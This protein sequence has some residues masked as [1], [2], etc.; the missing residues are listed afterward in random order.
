MGTSDYE[1]GGERRESQAHNTAGGMELMG[2]MGRDGVGWREEWG[3]GGGELGHWALGIQL[4]CLHDHSGRWIIQA[5]LL[6]DT[7][8]GHIYL[9]GKL[10]C[11][12]P[13]S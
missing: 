6:K 8:F 12:S 1:Q 2:F 4:G 10:Y 11:R 13:S 5:I 3:G 9:L 7:W